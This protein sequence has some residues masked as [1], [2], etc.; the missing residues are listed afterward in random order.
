MLI[1]S[2]TTLRKYLPNVFSTVEGEQSLF[3]KLTPYLSD[4]EVWTVS[5]FLSEELY[6]TMGSA[7]G[8]GVEVVLKIVVSQA[9]LNAVPSLDLVLTPNGFGVVSNSNVAPA[10]KDRVERLLASLEKNRDESIGLFLWTFPQIPEWAATSQASF[11]AATLFPDLSLCD[12]LGI[13]VNK[14][15]EYLK[16]RAHLI[17]IE[18][19][20]ANEYISP[21]LYEAFRK[22]TFQQFTSLA[23]DRRFL[24]QTLRFHEVA[25]LQGRTPHPQAMADIVNIIRSHPDT[26]PEWQNTDTAALFSPSKFENKKESGGYWF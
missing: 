23:T 4:A 22:D 2:D 3:E 12:Y 18:D 25:I 13:T 1:D 8:M 15:T 11:F 24:I 7:E 5:N 9:L 16:W 14:W 26:Y 6:Q 20:L 19:Q 17:S 21:E 10:S